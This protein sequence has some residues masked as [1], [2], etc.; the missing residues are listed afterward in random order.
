MIKKIYIVPSVDINEISLIQV[1]ATS[2]TDPDPNPDPEN[3]DFDVTGGG[4]GGN[5]NQNEDESE[6]NLSKR[7]G[8]FE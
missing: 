6:D 2:P 8:F 1:I 5:S 4:P 7:R 3:P